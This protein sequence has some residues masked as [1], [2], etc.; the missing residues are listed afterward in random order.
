MLFRSILDGDDTNPFSPFEV[1]DFDRDG[2]PDDIDPD[3][4]ND[5][6]D[7]TF[8]YSIGTDLLVPRH[9]QLQYLQHEFHEFLSHKILKDLVLDQ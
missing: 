5:N 4:D 9:Y 6:V 1:A 3:D 8:E 7:D 2:L